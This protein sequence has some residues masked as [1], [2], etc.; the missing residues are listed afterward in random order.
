MTYLTGITTW[1]NLRNDFRELICGRKADDLGTT[2]PVAERWR[3]GFEPNL[4][5]AV[6]APPAE[7]SDRTVTQEHRMGYWVRYDDCTLLFGAEGSEAQYVRQTGIWN[8]WHTS[9]K[10]VAAISVRVTTAN[11]T[12]HDYTG[13]VVQ[14]KIYVL[15][16][17]GAVTDLHSGING[18]CDSSGNVTLTYT[19]GYSMTL[20]VANPSTGILRTDAY[21]HRTFSTAYRGGFDA[22]RGYTKKTSAVT[23]TIAPSGAQG[24]DWDE[25]GNYYA[26]HSAGNYSYQH[27][28]SSSTTSAVSLGLNMC[29]GMGIKTNAALTGARYELT[30]TYCAGAIGYWYTS[31]TGLYYRY[32]GAGY[33]SNGTLFTGVEG[34]RHT[35][36]VFVTPFSST[37]TNESAVQYWISVTPT[38]LAVGLYGD[39]AQQGRVSLNMM[40]AIDG[41][42]VDDPGTSWAKGVNAE[43]NGASTFHTIASRMGP[44]MAVERASVKGYRD[45]GRDWQTGMGRYD[46]HAHVHGGS[47]IHSD[48]LYGYNASS[49]MY[50]LRDNR[51]LSA[52]YDAYPNGPFEYVNTQPGTTLLQDKSWPLSRTFVV[53]DYTQVNDVGTSG[54]YAG[55]FRP[56]GTLG[57][58]LLGT[59]Y[60]A[61]STGDELLDQATGKRYKLFG[62]NSASGWFGD[63]AHAMALEMF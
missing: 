49:Q 2:V 1:G 15:D 45:G 32:G 57:G 28:P 44:H 16:A 21:F 53:A 39:S 60:G 55:L 38:H 23:Y 10:D 58:G 34:Q 11:A 51:V 48:G 33:S 59:A 4:F 50:D 37:P 24:V 35:A 8:A 6:I 25:T 62:R 46:F 19:T 31:G 22:W 52:D 27:Q 12:A 63:R 13:A 47:N 5:N 43:G 56:R 54:F 40:G 42:D 30:F 26:G 18:T 17:S 7:R 41:F 61:W 9:F 36:K 20:R 14:M 29:W 3:D